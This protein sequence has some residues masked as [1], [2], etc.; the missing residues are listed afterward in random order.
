[1]RSMPRGLRP[2]LMKVS[3]NHSLDLLKTSSDP[4]VASD[5]EHNITIWEDQEEFQEQD[6][7]GRAPMSE[8][9]S[10]DGVFTSPTYVNLQYY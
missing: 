9:D 3:R 1:M 8:S 7:A 2:E 5:Q 4:F 10:E 6:A